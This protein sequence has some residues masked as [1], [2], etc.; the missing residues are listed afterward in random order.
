M[1]TISRSQLLDMRAQGKLLG[2]VSFPH[3]PSYFVLSSWSRFGRKPTSLNVSRVFGSR[4]AAERYADR[5]NARVLGLMRKG[6]MLSGKTC[7]V[8]RVVA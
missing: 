8:F 7:Y 5:E 6:S 3:D 2:M 4:V 1:V